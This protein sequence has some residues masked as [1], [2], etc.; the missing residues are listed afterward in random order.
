LEVAEALAALC[1]PGF[2]AEIAVTGSV[3]KG[4]ADAESDIELNFWVDTPPDLAALDSWLRS[5]GVER[6]WPDPADALGVLWL[7]F[8]WRDV[9]FEAGWQ[10]FAV[11]DRF[12]D[13]IYALKRL[14]LNEM[15]LAD[16]LASAIPLRPGD[17][18]SGWKERLGTYPDGLAEAVVEHVLSHWH[19]PQWVNA[20][21]A[22][23]RRG[24]SVWLMDHLRADVIDCLRL[25]F[26]LDRRWEP[27]WKWLPEVTSG[28]AV[29][30]PDLVAR[31]NAVFE[32]P[33]LTD[34]VEGAHRLVLDT[35]D[36]LPPSES[37]R[38]AR[39]TIAS[40]LATR[41]R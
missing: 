15:L 12:L 16:V 19:F 21:W 20:R 10:T 31:I 4:F 35:L 25:L 17:Y 38:Q 24:H 1:P 37:A 28:L 30:P 34:R 22:A 27:D 7:G 18:V 2:G 40:S 36:L 6:I 11:A 9:W 5:I 41:G 23:A 32:A 33:A 14:D 26:A 39:E 29:Q 13:E 8:R 3:S